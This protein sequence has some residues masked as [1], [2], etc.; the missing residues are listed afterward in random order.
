MKSIMALS[1]LVLS[2][3][4]FASSSD[5]IVIE[6]PYP[7]QQTA[8]YG[9]IARVESGIK[10]ELTDKA[11]EVCGTNENVAAIANVEVKFSFEI[12]KKDKKTFEGLYPLAAASAVAVCRDTLFAN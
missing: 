8:Y 7:T 9:T 11:I 12:I 6:V 1:F 3:N 5:G 4:T 2:F 10:Q